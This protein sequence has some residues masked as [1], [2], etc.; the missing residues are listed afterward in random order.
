[1]LPD[2]HPLLIQA[3][4]VSQPCSGVRSLLSRLRPCAGSFGRPLR[5]AFSRC[6]HQAL[7]R[8]RL[9]ARSGE[10]EDYSKTHTEVPQS[11]SFWAPGRWR[12]RALQLRSIS[13]AERG[14]YQFSECG[15]IRPI[16]ATSGRI[17]PTSVEF[18]STLA[19]SAAE[20]APIWESS[21]ATRPLW[22]GWPNFVIFDR[23]PADFGQSRSIFARSRPNSARHRPNLARTLLNLPRSR[24]NT[25]EFG[26]ASARSGHELTEFGAPGEAERE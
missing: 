11:C 3:R 23:S 12:E 6:A 1:M 24:P 10:R 25:A 21:G 2:D 8:R 16:G 4:A 15:A 17:R 22:P 13:V 14:P 18:G 5:L 26:P 20:A 9:P 19:R 7:Q